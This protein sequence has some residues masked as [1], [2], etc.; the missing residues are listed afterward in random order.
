[1]PTPTITIANP[2]NLTGTI[3]ATF[4]GD[5]HANLKIGAEVKLVDQ[6]G[7]DLCFADVLNVWAGNF[8]VMPAAILELAHEPIQRTF[9]GFQAHLTR[10]PAD[11]PLTPDVSA[12]ALI[13]KIKESTLLRPTNGQ[14]AK[15]G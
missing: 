15:L 14:I 9:A 2:T 12:T 7:Q 13:L 8:Q 11:G 6:K 5:D 3:A 1:M 10:D 4:R